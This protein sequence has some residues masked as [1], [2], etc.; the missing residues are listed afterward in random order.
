MEITPDEDAVKPSIR[1]I[2]LVLPEPE[3]PEITLSDPL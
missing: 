2:K 3:G 1:L